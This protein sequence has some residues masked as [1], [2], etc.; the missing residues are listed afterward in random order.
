[1]DQD[2]DGNFDPEDAINLLKRIAEMM[3][4]NGQLLIGV[5]LKKDT[6]ILDAAYNDAAG[7]TAEFNRNLLNRIRDELDSSI[8]PASFDHD[9]FY[10]AEQGRIEMHLV[11]RIPQSVRVE[12][13][14]FEFS[15]GESIHTENSYKYTIDEFGE[16]AAAAGFRQ[17]QVWTDESDLF[18]V[19][20]L[21]T[22]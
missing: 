21:Q 3:N 2:G 12:D 5:D 18:S 11:S 17:Q 19:Q 22:L 4:G 7:I 13:A 20:L 9:A 14:V 16:L 8:D 6:R 10:N 1:M 15:K